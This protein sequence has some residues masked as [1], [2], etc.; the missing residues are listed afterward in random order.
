[1]ASDYDAIRKE[2]IRKYGEETNLLDLLGDFLYSD[3]T[4]FVYEL[5]QNAEDAEAGRVE[6]ILY[7]DRLEVSHDGRPFD[8]ADVRGICGVCKS[9]KPDNPT[10]IGKF[11]IGFK[12]VYACTKAPEVH[13]GDEHFVIEHYVRPD[14]IKPIEVSAPW[15]TRFVFP[16]DPSS[17]S[18]G[19][20]IN[21]IAGRLK[22]LNVRT[23]LFLRSIDTITWQIEID[24]GESGCYMRDTEKRDSARVVNITGQV[25]DEKVVEESWLVFER[26]IDAPDEVPVKPVE[27]AFMRDPNSEQIVVT[28][29]PPLFVFFAT[30]KKNT[31]L[32][33]LVQG[34]YK[35]T[36]ARENILRDV[37]WNKY[38]IEE[39]AELV[40]D[41]LHRLKAMGLL[42]VPVLETM[43]IRKKDSE[44]GS[45]F[46]PLYDRVAQALMEEALLPTLEGGFVR[47]CDAIIGSGKEIR[48]LLS[49]EQLLVLFGDELK[50]NGGG[51]PHNLEWLS[52][53]I[54]GDLQKNLTTELDIEEVTPEK[55]AKRVDK[56]FFS[57]QADEWLVQLY[58]FLRLRKALWKQ[59]FF[60][61][62]NKWHASGPIRN[63]E[64]VRLDDGRHVS[65]FTDVTVFLP[66]QGARQLPK[67][68][69]VKPVLVEDKEAA[70]FFKELGVHEPDVVD[71]LEHHVLPL[72]EPD[73]VDV[74][75]E[76]HR[77][78]VNLIIKALR[79]DSKKKHQRLTERL[80]K[81]AF[82]VGRNAG[83]GKECWVTPQKLYRRSE[84][85]LVFLKGNPDAWFLDKRY[86]EEE[87]VIKA[88]L[89]LGLEENPRKQQKK[90]NLEG[91]VTI[92][93]E[94]YG[95]HERGL[96]G[97]DPGCDVDH[98]EFAVQSP[99]TERSRFIWNEIAIPLKYQIRG[100]VEKCTRKT[101]KG[102]DKERV[103]ST[104]GKQLLSN[105]AWLPDDSGNFHKPSDISLTDLPEEFV[106][107]EDLAGQLGMKGGGELEAL[108]KR[109]E[110]EL[111]VLAKR[112]GLDI[113]DINL[114]KKLKDS[115]ELEKLRRGKPSFPERPSPNVE[116][117][118][119]HAKRD[120]KGAPRKEYEKHSQSVRTSTAPG[121]KGT[122][123]KESYTNGEGQLVCQM[124]ENKMPF[125]KRNREYYFESVQVFDNLPHEHTAAYLALCPVCAAKYKEFVKKGDDDNATALRAGIS[126]S[127]LDK[128]AIP[129]KLV[130]QRDG[131]IRFVETHL[132]DIQEILKEETGAVIEK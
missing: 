54:T 102:S 131:S 132:L 95:N 78:H 79:V 61:G 46:R 96:D 63:K 69:T 107:D 116:R 35:T 60:D 34:P 53:R 97:F 56:Y 33:F 68:P 87:E 23:L 73:C 30:E 45:V 71:V 42:S 52:E 40:I 11:G 103:F 27:I 18:T 70:E 12:S 123:L 51:E 7:T 129:I 39:T 29:N 17:T 75:D 9:T 85:L 124:C 76:D 120:A 21:E 6:I 84:G 41:A 10:K 94:N 48:D 110:L 44:P 105:D 5:L 125:R 55:F 14:D 22:S 115:G 24:G 31:D 112:S 43:P 117:R 118:T 83:S 101:Y 26:A 90:P 104:L 19:A 77:E 67:L 38:L 64:F 20:A 106:R 74:S 121:D 99:T 8:E 4:H 66:H 130:G 111:E 15:T 36:L 3:Q 16:F 86:G 28:K 13:C 47:G 2:N 114:V 119:E 58:K 72:Y 32:G 108:A 1:M 25:D 49:S 80:K 62:F 128:L 81:T 122:Y 65:A 92:K 57:E 89:T 91:H 37:P 82:I 50:E 113:D 100:S 93:E 88:F 109:G 98:L 127:P 59:G 126:I